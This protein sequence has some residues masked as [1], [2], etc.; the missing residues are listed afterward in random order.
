M[1]NSGQ[2]LS[3]MNVLIEVGLNENKIKRFIKPHLKIREKKLQ[4]LIRT[5]HEII[6]FYP[7]NYEE[8]ELEK[9]RFI[10]NN[11]DLL[12]EMFTYLNKQYKINCRELKR[13]E[14]K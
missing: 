3:L 1:I 6:Y 8:H 11:K 10:L 5:C 2:I 14:K 7:H 13:G 4:I 12:R 9:Y